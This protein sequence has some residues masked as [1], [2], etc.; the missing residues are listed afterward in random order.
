MNSDHKKYHPAFVES[1]IRHPLCFTFREK[2]LDCL[3]RNKYNT[4]FADYSALQ[5]NGHNET[6]SL[7]C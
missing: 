7:K 2:Q 6:A 4:I 3:K 1:L 5:I